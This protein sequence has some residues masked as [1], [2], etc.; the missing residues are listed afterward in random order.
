FGDF[1]FSCSKALSYQSCSSFSNSVAWHIT[2]T[3]CSNRKGICRNGRSAKRC[4]D[5]GGSN[6]SSAYSYMFKSQRSAYVQCIGQNF[7]IYSSCLLSPE[8][9]HRRPEADRPE[10]QD[11]DHQLRQSC[12]YSSPQNSVMPD[13]D[14]IEKNV[15]KAHAGV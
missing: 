12:S 13:K 8:P 5:P 6:H 14:H 4:D 1:F 11:T 3:F 7:L 9:E 2:E 15:Q 10:H